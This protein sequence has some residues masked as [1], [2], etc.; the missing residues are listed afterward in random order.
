MSSAVAQETIHAKGY[1]TWRGE[2][3]AELEDLAAAPGL[4]YSSGFALATRI[5]MDHPFEDSMVRRLYMSNPERTAPDA[6][7]MLRAGRAYALMQLPGIAYPYGYSTH[8]EW[9][10]GFAA[11]RQSAHWETFGQTLDSRTLGTS[12]S[13]RYAAAKFLDRVLEHHLGICPTRADVGCGDNSGNRHVIL[14]DTGDR[15][16]FDN[17]NVLTGRSLGSLVLSKEKTGIFNSIIAGRDVTRRIVGVDKE[18]PYDPQTIVWRLACLTPEELV[19]GRLTQLHDALVHTE[20]G[21]DR[22]IFRRADVSKASDV[23]NVL[24]DEGAQFDVVSCITSFYQGTA[25][26]R[27]AKFNNITNHGSSLVRPGGLAYFIDFV[28]RT[29]D[30]NYIVPLRKWSEMNAFVWMG[31]ELTRVM[32]ATNGRWRSARVFSALQKFTDGGPFEQEVREL[33]A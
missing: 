31:G 30:N 33:V 4:P 9:I 2:L 27:R 19:S 11:M 12:I 25:K 24:Q 21:E 18:D 20:I 5:T 23:R 28:R 10:K 15:F 1:E 8:N 13:Q 26:Q 3:I 16:R 14:S 22:L 6:T 29:N 17:I 32:A 7:R